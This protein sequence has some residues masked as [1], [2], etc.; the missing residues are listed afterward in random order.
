MIPFGSKESIVVGTSFV[1]FAL[2]GLFVGF[3]TKLS[4]G[5]TSG[6]GL[7]G[8][9]RLS[10]RSLVAVCVFLLAAI[11]IGTLG[12]YVTSGPLSDQKFN[13]VIEINNLA[14]ANAFLAVGV[15]LPLISYLIAR[16]SQNFDWRSYLKEQSVLFAVGVIFGTG[17]MVSGMT[18]RGKIMRFLQLGNDWDPS[19]LFVLATGVV[20]NL[21]TFNYASRVK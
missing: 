12:Y 15:L 21:I 1:G 2:A 20:I 8:L 14:S 10:V 11:A 9:A 17:L 3:G 6:H 4:N 18:R 5:C 16:T 19:L 13:P 7:C